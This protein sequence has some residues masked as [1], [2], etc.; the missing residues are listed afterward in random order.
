MFQSVGS[1]II[2][3]GILGLLSMDGPQIN[4]EIIF[5]NLLKVRETNCG[6]AKIHSNLFFVVV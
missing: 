1:C 4:N 5:P 6:E 3:W 2:Y